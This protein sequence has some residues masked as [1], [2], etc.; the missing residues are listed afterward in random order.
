MIDPRIYSDYRVAKSEAGKLACAMDFE[1]LQA[2]DGKPQ[3][4]TT[5]GRIK[6]FRTWLGA[7]S[8]LYAVWRDRA[9]YRLSRL[10]MAILIE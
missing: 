6:P 1:L 9:A 10:P 2:P 7:W 8:W 3:V 5:T 4:R